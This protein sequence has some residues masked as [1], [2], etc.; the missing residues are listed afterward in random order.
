MAD[1]TTGTLSLH[2]AQSLFS[3]LLA[4][5]VSEVYARGYEL[6]HGDGP[7]L[8]MG[9][10]GHGRRARTLDGELVWV[11]DLVHKETGQHYRGLAQ[12]WNLFVAGEWVENAESPNWAV[13][14]ELGE[15]AEEMGLSWGG[16]F[17]DTNHISLA[18]G[19]HR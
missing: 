4:E 5:W 19:G 10:Q 3:K 15:L 11:R 7:I 16:R 9:P 8:P 2:Q 1:A 12:D 14:T 18:W 13:W 6:T 17:G